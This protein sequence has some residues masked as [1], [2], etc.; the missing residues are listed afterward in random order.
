MSFLNKLQH[1][2]QLINTL[3]AIPVRNGGIVKRPQKIIVGGMIE[4]W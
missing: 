4:N 1:L 3:K 2:N